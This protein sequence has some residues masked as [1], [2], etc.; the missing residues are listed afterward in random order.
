MWKLTPKLSEV[1]TSE[2]SALASLMGSRVVCDQF[3]SDPVE[4]DRLARDREGEASGV[5]VFDETKI[6]SNSLSLN[7]SLGFG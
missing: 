1:Q 4:L 5:V 7:W 3:S 2:T 6:S